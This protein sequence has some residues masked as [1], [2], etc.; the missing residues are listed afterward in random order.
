[1]EDCHLIV[2]GFAQCSGLV[3]HALGLHADKQQNMIDSN[4]PSQPSL[5][6]LLFIAMEN[7]CQGSFVSYH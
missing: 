1:M 7:P 6:Q 3:A 5:S 4:L 2:S